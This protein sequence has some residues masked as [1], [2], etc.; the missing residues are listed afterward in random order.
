MS[1]ILSHTTCVCDTLNNSPVDQLFQRST[2]WP[3]LEPVQPPPFGT[4]DPEEVLRVDSP[5]HNWPV[6]LVNVPADWEPDS[7]R[8]VPPHTPTYKKAKT[9]AE[10]ASILNRDRLE[11]SKDGFVQSWYIRVRL[12]S[13]YAN[14]GVSLPSPWKPESEFDLPPA[15]IRI[16]G[17]RDQCMQIVGELNKRLD[18][19]EPGEVRKRAY[20][21]RSICPGDLE[22]F[23][24][25]HNDH[26][27]K[28]GDTVSPLKKTPDEKKPDTVSGLNETS[29]EKQGGNNDHPNNDP[30]EIDGPPELYE[31][32]EGH[33]FDVNPGCGE[34]VLIRVYNTS[35]P[36][37]ARQ[38]AEQYLK[39]HAQDLLEWGQLDLTAAAADILH[40][41]GME[42]RRVNGSH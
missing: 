14:L 9:A 20:I 34:E 33:T 30:E 16:D 35:D 5:R 36:D 24:S 8:S 29:V 19:C 2:N 31:V 15:F 26:T 38:K 4:P 42:L 37:K 27:G 1:T 17:P 13:K 28:K 18:K 12:G 22:P 32:H 39:R 40:N 25:A 21:A 3:A 6:Y 7:W 41:H 10:I 11:R 23:P